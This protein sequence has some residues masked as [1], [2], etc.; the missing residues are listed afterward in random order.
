MKILFIYPNIGSQI[1]FNYGIA[2][3]SAVLKGRGHEVKLIQLCEE[4]APVPDEEEFTKMIKDFSP[5]V[6]GFSVVTNQFSYACK[7][8]KIARATVNAVITCGGVHATVAP[9]ETVK[10]DLFD[11]VFVGECDE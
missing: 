4:I 8:A 6:I 7:F 2:H 10:T 3:M 5:D 9:E 11:Y 1:G